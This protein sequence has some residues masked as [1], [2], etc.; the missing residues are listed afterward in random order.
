MARR[1]FKFVVSM[2][3]FSKF[4]KEEHKN[5]EFLLR[6]YPDLQIAFGGGAAE[7]GGWRSEDLLVA[8]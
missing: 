4:N 6:A 3:W 5:A 1:E 7:E 8:Y 2:Q